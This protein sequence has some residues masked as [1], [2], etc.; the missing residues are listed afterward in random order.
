MSEHAHDHHVREPFAPGACGGPAIGGRTGFSPCQRPVAWAGSTSFPH[1]RTTWHAFTCD[2]HRWHLD[3]PRALTDDDRAELEHRREQEWRGR[4]GLT[5][6]R[7]R[8]VHGTRR[9]RG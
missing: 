8:P 1:D 3:D 9:R 2:A 6:E 7:I 4:S 5:Y